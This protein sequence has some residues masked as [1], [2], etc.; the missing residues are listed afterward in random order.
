MGQDLAHKQATNFWEVHE[1]AKALGQWHR[2]A[3]EMQYVK[4]L[5]NRAEEAYNYM[6]QKGFLGDWN[7]KA[8]EQISNRKLLQAN[9]DRKMLRKREVSMF[10]LE[11]QMQEMYHS[12]S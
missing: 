11:Q 4:N 5:D 10:L 7:L 6:K 2:C 12:K 8:G 9:E 3:F 1:T